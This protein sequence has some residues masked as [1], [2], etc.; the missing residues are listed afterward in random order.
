MKGE[1]I[2]IGLPEKIQYIDH[3]SH[4]EIVR[5]W[6]G[7]QIL[8][9]TAFAIFWDG[10]L[11]NWYSSIPEDGPLIVVLIPLLHVGV[12]VGLTY[13]VIAGWFNRTHIYVGR[14]RIG[15]RHGPIPWLGNK[16]IAAGDVKQLYA[17]EK[18]SRGR[19]SDHATYEV[20]AVTKSGRNIQVVGGLASQE[21]AIFIEQRIEKYLRIEDAAV[22]GEINKHRA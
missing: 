4:I 9:L 8:F 19:N 15:I 6:F 1:A 21:Q 5:K 11:Y 22:P 10:F 7:V 2:D 17:K 13:Y 14:G 3:L 20:R 16:E 18:F 12:G